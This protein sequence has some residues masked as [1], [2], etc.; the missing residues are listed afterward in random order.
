MGVGMVNKVKNNPLITLQQ[1]FAL[2]DLSG[3]H[4]VIDLG[5]V[6]DFKAGNLIGDITFYK[7]IEAELKMKRYLESLP[8]SCNSR[9]IVA[10]F[11]MSP[12]TICFDCTAFTP[13]STSSVTLNFWVGPI[14]NAQQG[15]WVILENYLRE[16]ICASDDASYEY[17][18]SFMAHMVQVPEEKPGVMIVLLGGQ[19]TGKGVFFQLLN[20]IWP[21]TTLLVSDSDQV[22]GRFNAALERSFAI[23]MD[24]A[25][26]AGDK[27]A[28][29]RLKS[30]VT[31]PLL[32]VEQKYQPTRV[33][34]SVH[35]FFAASNH[36]HFAQVDRDDSRFLFL[37]VSDIHKQDT[38]YFAQVVNAINDPQILRALLWDLEHIDL[39]S[40]NVRVRPKTPE[41]TNQKL[42]SL[43]GFDRFWYEI[44][45]NGCNPVDYSSMGFST[46]DSWGDPIFV[47]T[48]SLVQAYKEH[49]R[50]TPIYQ[51][52]QSQQVVDRLKKLC[53]SAQAVRKN[54][55]LSSVNNATR[56]RGFDLPFLTTAR[57]E[58]CEAIGDEV[59]WN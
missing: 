44:L 21:I 10:D 14:T 24:E 47:A 7:R 4:R 18:I 31:E 59:T 25:L 45:I 37:R 46:T 19:G 11:F 41:H 57:Q 53:P 50:G 3:E 13:L 27:K 43:A 26:F 20:A 51:S 16:V 36:D 58:F 38:H 23:C 55:N 56:L 1:R 40:F 28:M 2:I 30:T 32:R 52:I 5:R 6:A 33:I 39:S 12:A 9:L 15:S 42:K 35:R 34:D 49:T 22:V 8:I 29:D 48:N 54:T 17:L